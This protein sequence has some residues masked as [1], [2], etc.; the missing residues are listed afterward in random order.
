M[1]DKNSKSKCQTCVYSDSPC[2]PSDYKKDHEGVCEH[3]RNIFI[4]HTELEEKCAKLEQGYVW[5]D[6]DAG[7]DSYEDSHE[8]RWVKRDEVYK[9]DKATDLLKKLIYLL[10]SEDCD[11]TFALKNTHLVLVEAEQFLR[12]IE[13]N[14]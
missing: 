13:E 11:Y 7:E 2:V 12:E 1:T 9:L 10:K 3:F 4:E 6:Y 14:D 5:H 8:G